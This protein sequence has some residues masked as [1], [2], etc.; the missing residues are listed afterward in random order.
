[1]CRVFI[2]IPLDK[3]LSR[4]LLKHVPQGLKTLPRRSLHITLLFLGNVEEGGIE[5]LKAVLDNLQSASFEL[6]FS[7]VGLFPNADRPRLLAAGFEESAMA[8]E[9]CVNLQNVI[10]QLGL[11][12]DERPYRPHIT[13]ARLKYRRRI[14]FTAVPLIEKICVNEIVLYKSTL[15]SDGAHYTVLH[16]KGLAD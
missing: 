1:M 12:V 7:H 3:Q 6:N 13:L 16:K 9:L 10:R 2:A 5:Q 4:L 11:A 14:S 8:Q 15:S